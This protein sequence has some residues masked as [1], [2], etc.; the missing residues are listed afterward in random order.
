MQDGRDG[1][2][3]A[4]HILVLHAHTLELAHVSCEQL[5]SRGVDLANFLGYRASGI[6]KGSQAARLMSQEAKCSGGRV[7]SIR[8]G[9]ISASLQSIGATEVIKPEVSRIIA[10]ELRQGGL[11]RDPEY[12]IEDGNQENWLIVELPYYFKSSVGDP[13]TLINDYSPDGYNYQ[14]AETMLNESILPYCTMNATN[15]TFCNITSFKV[16]KLERLENIN[17]FERYKRHETR[18]AKAMNRRSSPSLQPKTSSSLPNWLKKLSQKNGLS[19]EAN[20]VYLLHGTRKKNLTQIVE[21]GLKTRF[22]MHRHGTYGRGLYFT[23]NSCKASQYATDDDVILVCRV[24]LGRPEVLDAACPNMLFPSFGHDSA[25]AKKN[26]TIAPHG[27]HQL[28]NEYI[29]Y[30]ECS[31]YPEFVIHFKLMNR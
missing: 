1:G 15:C 18:V 26:H 12:L 17:V 3:G 29:V 20:A 25:M 31:C 5:R 6:V 16:L 28:H 30:D 14:M 24:V 4:S 9:G 10:H 11:L 7:R 2:T 22:S 19:S 13:P 27:L 21:N 23:D 8:Q